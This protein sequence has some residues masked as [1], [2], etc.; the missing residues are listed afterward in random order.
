MEAT[1]CELSSQ[2][3]RP[4]KPKY[5]VTFNCYHFNRAL[6]WMLHV[7]PDPGK[8]LRWQIRKWSPH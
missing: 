3:M 7:L 1:M 6:S 2:K 8:R 4:K 5:S